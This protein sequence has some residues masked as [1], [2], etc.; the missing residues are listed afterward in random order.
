MNDRA[1]ALGLKKNN[2]I[3]LTHVEENGESNKL[4]RY[5]KRNVEIM[6]KFDKLLLNIIIS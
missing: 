1:P 2:P 5:L 6:S 4:V 3:E